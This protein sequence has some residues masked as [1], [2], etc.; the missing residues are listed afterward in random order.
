LKWVGP[1]VHARLYQYVDYSQSVSGVSFIMESLTVV[2]GTVL[3]RKRSWCVNATPFD[4]EFLDE[5]GSTYVALKAGSFMR[6]VVQQISEAKLVFG[7]LFYGMCFSDL[8]EPVKVS[9]NMCRELDKKLGHVVRLSLPRSSGG[10]CLGNLKLVHGPGGL[11]LIMWSPPAELRGMPLHEFKRFLEEVINHPA[12]WECIVPGKGSVTKSRG[13]ITTNMYDA[14]SHYIMPS[15]A[16]V[17]AT[18][19]ELL[20]DFGPA[21]VFLSHVWAETASN[22]LQSLSHLKVDSKK[23]VRNQSWLDELRAKQ[24]VGVSCR[25][26]FCTCCNNQQRVAE[27]IGAN[28][29]ESAFARVIS[30]ET[31]QR[32][33]LVSPFLALNRKWCTFE[34]AFAIN[35]GKDILTMTVDG[36]VEG[37]QVAPKTLNKLAR[38]L[39]QFTC[40]NATC[41][42]PEDAVLKDNA[43]V[44]LGGIEKLDTTLRRALGE[45]VMKAHAFTTDAV[46]RCS[47]VSSDNL[48]ADK[49]HKIIVGMHTLHLTTSLS[50][51]TS[52]NSVL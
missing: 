16:T 18:Y 34:F 30:S 15:I 14:C 2:E 28:V 10:Q 12:D 9:L 27:A 38:H 19:A 33:V 24:V 36:V 40:G 37:G 26:W 29:S 42:S 44:D 11:L 8:E 45:A 3:K 39:E 51:T 4:M 50:T 32:V 31:C 1:H 5:T 35:L 46:N 6:V 20:T 52:R 47:A 43:I 25:V 17:D 41:T 7:D 48:F 49:K 13:D 22:T 23:L 21:D